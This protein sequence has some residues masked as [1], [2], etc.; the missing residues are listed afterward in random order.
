[1]H[2]DTFVNSFDEVGE[3]PRELARAAAA[4]GVGDRVITLGIGEQRVE[5]V[6][7]AER[8]N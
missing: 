5:R 3:A 8:K 6:A 1:M 7:R 4:S 2:Y